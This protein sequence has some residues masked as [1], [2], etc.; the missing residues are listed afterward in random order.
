M[1]QHQVALQLGQLVV[2]DAALRQL[3]EAGVDAVD[4]GVGVDDVLHRG[5]RGAHAGPGRFGHGQAHLAAVD[6]AQVGQ[7]DLARLQGQQRAG[8][9]VVVLAGAHL[10]VPVYTA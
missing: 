10:Y 9:L 2:R 1:R 7:G 8:S 5:L 3:A 4:H 6:A